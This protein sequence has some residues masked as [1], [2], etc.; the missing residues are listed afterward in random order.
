MIKKQYFLAL[1]FISLSLN[2]LLAWNVTIQNLNTSASGA[3]GLFSSDGELIDGS[4]SSNAR[5]GSFGD[6]DILSLW[7]AADLATLDASFTQFGAT[8]G[9]NDFGAG[10]DGTFQATVDATVSNS[11][12]GDS[13]VLWMTNGG[14]FT[15]I[16]VEH[17]I[18]VFD[19]Q[20]PEEP[21]GA[22]DI[23]LGESAG[24][25]LV[26]QFGSYSHDYTLGS[27]P[28]SGF[29]TVGAV[30]EPSAFAAIA[31]ALVLGFAAT[32]RRRA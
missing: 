2:P 23:L 12:Q 10:F 7:G 3:Y 5:I 32:R 30:P 22:S 9:M 26:G 4:V 6:A 18:Y 25:L 28:L 8:F 1:G 14:S 31:G 27:G 24:T 11:I 16:N 19:I 17:L 13:V 29:N 20:F 15:D 21:A